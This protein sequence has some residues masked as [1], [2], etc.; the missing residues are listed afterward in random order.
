MVA[1]EIPADAVGGTITAWFDNEVLCQDATNFA[2][3]AGC[4][5]SPCPGGAG[6]IGGR[7]FI[8][9][10]QDGIHQAG[11]TNG[12]ADVLVRLYECNASGASVF[13]SNTTT[14]INGDYFFTGLTD[15]QKYRLEFEL[16]PTLLAAGLRM[17]NNGADSRTSVQFYTAPTCDVEFGVFP[18]ADFCDEN[19]L[20][21]VPCYSRGNPLVAGSAA[22]DPALVGFQ[23]N[24]TGNGAKT[25]YAIQSQVGSLW[26]EAYDK[27]RKRMYTSS[28]LRR[29]AGLGPHGLYGLYVTDMTLSPAASTS[30]FLDL[31]TVGVNLGTVSDNPGRGLVGDKTT[32][33][34]DPEAF[35]KLGKVGIG[36]IDISDD[37]STLYF[38]NLFS[39]KLQSLNIDNDGNPATPYVHTAADV[40]EY[41][42][43]AGISCTG[44]NF[45]PFALKFY[46]GKVY[47]GAVCDAQISQN[48]SDLRAYV[49]EFTPGAN[50][51][52][53]LFDFPLT[54]PKG[55]PFSS[56][57]DRPGWYPWT[58]TWSDITALNGG[59]NN[60]AYPTP[61][62]CDIEFDIDGS[63]VLGF[64]DRTAY[65][66]GF[67]DYAP[68]GPGTLYR[69]FAGGDVL[70]VFTKNGSY[71]LE[72][73]GQAG[74]TAGF[75]ANNNQGPGFGEFY[76]DIWQNGGHSEIMLGGLA[77]R[78]GSG[79]V[80]AVMMDP[81]LLNPPIWSNGVRTLSNLT[82]GYV[83]GF[84]VFQYSTDP[85][86]GTFGKAAGLGDIE[87]ICAIP[88]NIQIGNRVWKDD[89][90]N[91]IQEPCE[92]PIANVKVELYDADGDLVG[93]T[94]TNANGE[95]YF[96]QTNVDTI[97]PYGTGGFTGMSATTKYFVVVGKNMTQFNT[98]S[99]ELKIGSTYYKLSLPPNVGQAPDFDINDS[100][101]N[102]LAGLTGSLASL[103]GYPGVMITSPG[104]G[105]VNH[106][107]DFA[108]FQMVDCGD[109]PD[110][111]QAGAY[112]TNNTNG[113]G[114]G[115]GACHVITSALKMGAL[116]DA[117]PQGIPST[118]ADGDDTGASDDEDGVS[119]PAFLPGQ[120][121]NITVSVM[122]T[123]GS[124]AK[125]T[126]FFDW[127]TDGDFAD[128]GEM[129]SVNV[130]D[131]TNGN[132]I[133]SVSVPANAVVNQLLGMR[134]RLST[135]AAASMIPVGLAPNGEVE[136]YL[137]KVVSFDWGDLPDT[138]PGTGMG[139]YQVTAADNGPNH[140]VV[141]NLKIGAS[142][143]NEA[144]GQPNGTATGDGADENGIAAFPQFSLGQFAVVDVTVMN[145]TG[146]AAILYGFFD[147]NKD[148][149][150]DDA[151]EQTSVAVPNG[152]NGVLQLNPYVP[153]GAVV[154]MPLGAR[155]RLSTDI[156]AAA[157]PVGP[158]PDGEV[159]DYLITVIALDYGDLP[160]GDNPGSY[161]TNSTDGG[162]GAG[163]CHVIVDGLK[164]GDSV[165]G[166]PDGQ[167]N[168]TAAGD[169]TNGIDD[170]NGIAAFPMFIA[171]QNATVGVNVM[172]T[173]GSTAILYGFIDWN[174]DG[175]FL[176][177]N[178][179]VTTPVVNNTMGVVNLNFSVPANAVLNMDLGARFR[180]S[181]AGNLT[182]TGPSCA[183]NGEVE[184]YL[185]RVM[186]FDYGDLPDTGPGT[187][188]G[189][190]QTLVSDNGPSHKIVAGLKMGASVDD[191][192]NGQ[193][194]PTA[195]GDGADEN[196]VAAFPQFAAGQPAVIQVNVMNMTGDQA[197]LYGFFDWNKDG[198]F[199]DPNEITSFTVPDGTNGNV[200]L[201]VNVPGD[202][203]VNMPL[204]ARLRLSTDPVAPS[205]PEGP[206]PD[207]EVEDY[208]VTVVAIDYG[209]LAD[210]NAPGSY[211]TDATNGGGEGVGPS[212]VINPNLKLGASVDGE[213]AGQP[214][215]D[216]NGDD[217]NKTP[218]D[219]DGVTI[220]MFV[221][222]TPADV[223]I[224]FMNMTGGNAKLTLFI[225][226]NGNGNFTDPGEMYSTTV[227]N[228]AANH[229]FNV[230]PPPGSVLNTDIGVRVRL[231]TDVAASMSP[232]GPAPDGEVEDYEAQ[233]MAFDFGDLA[234]NDALG[235][236][237]TNT[238]DGGGEGVGPSHKI[239]AGLKMG[240][241]IDSETDG[242][243]NA[244]ATGD[245]A[246]ED[247]IVSFPLFAAG[248]PA[249][250]DVYVMNMTGDQAVLYGF[251]DWN[252]DG[253]FDDAN[254][255]TKL[256]VPDG[257]NNFVPLNVNVPADVVVNMPLGA[258]FRLSTDPV[259]PSTAEGPAP[260]GEVEDYQI[261]VVAIDYGDL[262][263]ND[264]PGSYPTNTTDGG[265]G[266]G[267]GHVV[268]PGI[269]IGNRVDGEPNG[270]PSATAN[271]DD[272]NGTPDDEDGVVLP[273]LIEGALVNVPVSVM[274]MRDLDA[275]LTIFIDW[276][277]NGSFEPGEMYFTTVSSGTNGIVNVPVQVP[278]GPQLNTDLGIRVRLST[279][280]QASMSPTGL[281]PDGEVE[282]YFGQV[283][284]FDWGDLP[285][286]NNGIGYATNS[287][288]NGEGFGPSHKIVDG[289]KLGASVDGELDGQASANADG[290]DTNA[291]DENGIAAFPTFLAGEATTI[292]VN[293]MNMTGDQ[294]V[295]FGFIDWNKDGDFEDP[296]EKVSVNVPDGT[297]GVMPLNVT[298]PENAVRN[299]PLGAR[300]RLSTDDVAAGTPEGPAPDGEV[301]DY[302]VEVVAYD[303]G[304]LPDD[305]PGTGPG[306]YETTP[307]D[308]GP[309]HKVVDGLKLGDNVDF[310][311]A[312]QP[313]ANADGDD[314]A[315][316]DDENGVQLPMFEVNVPADISV[317]YMNMTGGDAKLTI[318]IDWNGDGDFNDPGEMYATTVG[319]NTNNTTISV[320][321]P[322]GAV[323]NQNIGIRTRLSTDA[324]ASMSPTGPAP[325][326]EV[327]DQ[328]AQVMAFDYGDL[329]D[330]DAGGAYPTN[331]TD[332]GEGV[333][334]S[335]KIVDGLKLGA[336][337]DPETDGQP[338]GTANGDDSNGVDDENGVTFPTLFAGQPADLTVTVMNMTGAPA[339][340]FTYIDWNKDGD[341]DDPGEVTQ[342]SIL[343]GTNGPVQVT[344]NV[345]STAVINMPLGARFRLTNDPAFNGEP[346][347]PAGPGEVEDYYVQVVGVDYGDLADND[348]PGSYP[349]NTTDGGEGVGPS[350]IIVDGLKIGPSVDAEG[351][352]QSSTG[353]NGDD[354]ADS[355]DENGIAAFPQFTAGENA[356]VTVNV[357]NMTEGPAKLTG[358]IDWNGDG[359][360]DDAGEMTSVAV[361][362]GTNG[363]VDLTFAVPVN[364][365]L[366]EDLG[367]RFRLST[368]AQASMSP[369]GPAPDGEVEDYNVQ[370]TCPAIVSVSA[371]T[372]EVCPDY[373]F[374]VTVTHTPSLGNLGIY[375]S[376][377]GALTAAELYDFAN[378]GANGILPLE[379]FVVT[380]D[381]P[382]EIYNQTIPAFGNFTIYAILADG[383]PFISDPNCLPM[384]S[385]PITV[386]DDNPPAI[387]CPTDATVELDGTITGGLLNGQPDLAIVSSG[388]CGVTLDYTQ[389]VGTDDCPN[390][391]TQLVAGFGAAPN[392]YE[393]NG[394]YTSVWQVT[395]NAGH[396]A[397]CSF[398]V[399]IED[400]IPPVITC[401][402]DLTINT[403][404]GECDAAVTYAH[405]LGGDNCPGF[406][407]NLVQGPQSGDEF[408]LGETTVEYQITDDMG[409]TTTC[410]FTV[411]V[412][413]KEKP[414]ISCPD[415][416]TVYTSSDGLGD[417]AGLVPNF[418]PG[419]SSSD[420]CTSPLSNFVQ[421]PA[422]GTSVNGAH[423]QQFDVVITVTDAAGN[424]NSCE[425][426][427][428]L[429]DDEAPT[430]TPPSTPV[431]VACAQDVPAIPVLTPA[432]NCGI[433][434]DNLDIDFSETIT[435]GTCHDQFTLTRTWIVTDKAGNT[436]SQVQVI[437][438]ND[439]AA[440]VWNQP[441]PASPLTYQCA[442]DVPA[443][444]LQ[445]ANDNCGKPIYVDFNEILTPGT[446]H[447][448]FTIT[449]TWTAMDDC[450]NATTRVQVINVNDTTNPFWITPAP[451]A[452]VAVNCAD[453]V[454]LPSIQL[455]LD[456]CRKPVDLEYT[457]VLI[458][459]DCHDQFS[460]FRTWT[461]ADDCGNV[462]IRTQ[463]VVVEDAIKPVW[464]QLAPEPVVNVECAEDVPPAPVQT[465]W[466]N[467]GVPIDVELVELELPGT[468]PNQ[469][470]ITRTWTAEDACG[471]SVSRQQVINV[472]D[473]QAPEWLQPEPESPVNL[474]CQ[475]DIPPVPV[476]TVTDNCD[477]PVF[478]EFSEVLTPGGCLNSFSLTRTWF[479]QDDCGNST[480]RQ[481]V[482]NVN[483]DSA[484]GFVGLPA[485]A[486]VAVECSEDVP[487][488][489]AV[490]A[491]DNC[492]APV[493]VEFTEVEIPGT[494]PNQYQ[495]VRT[496]TAE[497]AC[498][499]TDIFVQTITISD[500]KA[501]SWNEAAPQP[502]VR[503][504]CSEDVP[505]IPAQTASDN[506]NAP[507][508]LEFNESI[509]PGT[510]A[511]Q[512]SLTRTWTAEDD[513]GNITTR[514]QVI[515]VNDGEKPVL[516]GLPAEALVQVECADAVPDV[517]VV[518]ATDN[519]AEPIAPDFTEVEEP[520]ACPNQYTIIRT[521]TAEDDCGNSTYFVQ[522]II[523][524]DTEAPVLGV[525]PLDLNLD[526][527]E[528][529]PAAPAQWATDNCGV[530]FID[531]SESADPG[532][533]SCP[534]S[535]VITRMWIASDLCGNTTSWWQT[536]TVQDNEPP[537]LAVT[538]IDFTVECSDEVPL[539]PS[540]SA[541]DNCGV[542][543]V[544]FAEFVQPGGCENQYVIA[545]RWIATDLCGNADEH[546]QF[547]TVHD[548]EAP[549]LPTK[550]IDLQV[551]CS[552]DVP[553]AP[554][555]VAT[556][557]CGIVFVD[558]AEEIQPGGCENQYVVVRRWTATDLCGNTAEHWQHITVNDVQAPVLVGLPA[559]VVV[560]VECSEDVPSVPAVFALDNCDS[561][562]DLE[563]TEIE[564]PG[565]CPN[566]YSIVRTWSVEDACGNSKV[567]TQT[568]N[569]SDTE[570]PVLAG[571]P[572]DAVVHVEC[573]EDM[574]SVPA[575]TATDNCDVPIVVDFSEVEIPGTCAN[576]Y[577]ITRTWTAQD[578]C[579]NATSFVQTIN[580]SDTEAPALAGLP[581][582]AVVNVECS[583]DVPAVPAVTATDNC[584]VPIVVDFSEVE[585]PGTCPNQYS[586]T[587]TWTAQDDCGNA[588][589]FV[590]TI[591]VS[592]T[593]APVLSG[594]PPAVVDVACSEDVPAMAIVTAIDNC[595]APVDIEF[596]EKEIPG[597][598]P[599]QYSI[600][601]TWTAEDDCGNATSFVQTINV[602]DT[603]APVMAGLPT[604]AVVNLECSEDVPAV[605]VVTVTDNCNQLIILDFNEVETPGTCANQYS[606][607]RTW[608]AQDDCGN[609]TSFVQTI[610]VSDTEAPVLS[611]L[612]TEAV[613]NVECSE[614]VPAVP[615]VSATDNCQAPIVVDFNEVETPGT[616]ANQYSITRTWTAQDDCGN[617]T[618]FVQ[619]IN[620]SD[621]EA[622]ALAG[623]PTDAVVNVECSED[624]PAVPS[625]SATDNC[626]API[627]VD[628]SEVEIPGTCPN[629]YTITRTWSAQDDCG[630]ATSFVQTINVSDTEAPVLSGL[631]TEA[632]V[633]V[634]CSEDVPAVP[635]VSATDNCQAPIAVDFSEVEIPG[636][637]P[638]QY[639]IT[640]TW[641]AQDDC[642]NATSFVQTINV[643][644]TEAPALAGL[645]TDAVVNVECS[646]D[647]PAVP[648]VSATDN[649]QAPIVVDFSEVE[650][651]GTCP[652]QYTI[653][654]TWSVQDDCGNAT[655]FVQTINVS[656]T[657]APVLSGLPTDAVVNVE[658]SEDVPAVPVVSATDNCQA[659]IVV[660]FSEVEAPGSCAN[661]Y[662]I[663][664]TWS[665]QDDCG[666]AASF[667]QTINVNDDIAP[668]ISCPAN[669]F[670]QCT[671]DEIPVYDNLA[672]FNTAGGAASDNCGLD[673]GTFGLLS[674]TQNGNVYTRTY[675]IA[676]ACG[677]SAT[678]TQTITVLDTEAPVFVNC[679]ANITVGNDVDKC[680]ANVVFST[681]IAEDNCE[682][683]S[684]TQ[685]GGLP[686]GSL[687]PVGQ[688]LITF[689]AADPTGNTAVC[690][691]TIEVTDMQTPT[692]V[693][694]DLTVDLDNA[695]LAAISAVQIG[696][697]STDNCPG[698]L[699]LH[700]AQQ[701][702]IVQ[703]SVQTV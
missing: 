592:D 83:N 187:G 55:S 154:N 647:V 565:T 695:G 637:C 136:D 262:P 78:P 461:A 27:D 460:I 92:D 610:N 683:E 454:P 577:S 481:Q 213:P 228:L 594:L 176:D 450:G 349:T 296:N 687:F 442:E 629:Q 98:A 690:Q 8:D 67:D 263:D 619:T 77:L 463:L 219:E 643:S 597:T 17:G 626:Q 428:T 80:M 346:T 325:D 590:Q 322:A 130:P 438:V 488:V 242:Q 531:F 364:S 336:S 84:V 399:V 245:G 355:D 507:V 200:P 132:V 568:I 696:G 60:I 29:H 183:P 448:Q 439:T 323:L 697:N 657:E 90:Q 498:G 237:P 110:D 233:V 21:I 14:D 287:N 381:N 297:N 445:T 205:S 108:F 307:G 670:A 299:M 392:Y 119:L 508:D 676:D 496:W 303:Y 486:T 654:R 23:Y 331:D 16:T 382:T 340:L 675:V 65:Q 396:T 688:T 174:K 642:G 631:P 639:T 91:G 175:D 204:G 651:P 36:D 5:P 271:G 58:D 171:G 109:L 280:A 679:P 359:D 640:R 360:F 253:D 102:Y 429:V 342:T 281:A 412:E 609:A 143:D 265:E 107:Y 555:Q 440:P 574:P 374:D 586:I 338:S 495:V 202:V 144:D 645:P 680:G 453:D 348:A 581:T 389:P 255:S 423:G 430:L 385:T 635:V 449:R 404:P 546:W 62:F 198:D 178:E 475:E 289:L 273:M 494:C 584:D 155:F 569:V 394:T 152:Y 694:T 193:P 211:P 447:D 335:H 648:S 309:S 28:F 393:Y 458:P 403:D 69:G 318:F 632:V 650:I 514:V 662:V 114:E 153:M 547:I 535:T 329:A 126:G 298:V 145:M 515:Q 135:D 660:D 149:D 621:T 617:A 326:G 186:A 277:G 536:I 699:I 467:C 89:N 122:N 377:N 502:L 314:L 223:S 693:C 39:G 421:S 339:E 375:Y 4:A 138:G 416:V 671:V 576:Q 279:D 295:L 539:A 477:V 479:A 283:M 333:G 40:N 357:M 11:E 655:S 137:A 304:D 25:V 315:G 622:P 685:T 71:V 167:P 575:V 537:V 478:V 352:G 156:A 414:E 384:A 49:L 367:A 229:V 316:A 124:T 104:F 678:C 517:P 26:G 100:D 533:V 252:K 87:L 332:G 634:E 499:N 466:D 545:R 523:V 123:T 589:S 99:N 95:Y 595:D 270:Q 64:G 358:F 43:T 127:N 341:L 88:T 493:D 305:A 681:P 669:A 320:T 30:L 356:T 150:F 112:P 605:P 692:A 413:D 170:D 317:T 520:G 288:N 7:A 146:Q 427:I 457:E 573:S 212:H 285:D 221:L 42:I 10:N 476:Q 166:D 598:C 661:Q 366:N 567:F 663:T 220:P 275:K 290:D 31:S 625:V 292:N 82:G 118:N 395:D 235:S 668:S 564:I 624:V 674:Q 492:D 378:H 203:V 373:E 591:N 446:C 362:D 272:A 386:V 164:I 225:D 344:V 673:A 79:Q 456:N 630:N 534:N 18:P 618:S 549:V 542:V 480:S 113:A 24:A 258:R 471:N 548:D 206:A 184:D 286:L 308:N 379:D 93:V 131:G 282:D 330:D 684:V 38:V 701:T 81:M 672:E 552:E 383:N 12:Q 407:F 474:A 702:L 139:N 410:S 543:N 227:A 321:P 218:D 562:V 528:D 236:Y 163:P 664:R 369:T 231:S 248:Q 580:V 140:Q 659:P 652:N 48:K 505:P 234:D 638:N 540:Q 251:F 656:D 300:F 129:A 2:P 644:D 444:P 484:P 432:D 103:N 641:S 334:A 269:K 557:N 512:F 337:V 558:F 268:V 371:S 682:V 554:V 604:E 470:Q 159:E 37:G 54:Y 294:A 433:G 611:G 301:E 291:D 361:P 196:G 585:I 524:N 73:N 376:T 232:T 551:N 469:L 13:V 312:G 435:P 464:N 700:P 560:D 94:T 328:L 620:V 3:P 191:E 401:P 181:T 195:T 151:N 172:N 276:N 572:T 35:T 148:G 284:A 256:T 613:V 587:R 240:G 380:G 559:D 411:T 677:N 207:G 424:A 388:P 74:T 506:C 455:A 487:A 215:I 208:L 402:D 431:N 636:T 68:T 689:V 510:C 160:D 583:E 417:C 365:E 247:G 147:W 313:A 266:P 578:D 189:N 600:T 101:G 177:A 485:E 436:T 667:V 85:G 46:K 6:T 133:L 391:L 501:P 443:V 649:C 418:I 459:G 579:G 698:P 327:E 387:T 541:S 599:N 44:G 238:L 319:N 56:V 345:P 19:P 354:L 490:T 400:P 530:V 97:A 614:D 343:N 658:C 217:N 222:N 246:D 214:S 691:F 398:T 52:T 561:P 76:N 513:C 311:P 497:D 623:L 409:N 306:N 226:W 473:T 278:V 563:F 511:N 105:D 157:A 180:I 582:E 267:A 45:R 66:L 86:T 422:A 363:N 504:S 556:D 686:S 169:D 419:T 665:A 566:Q 491:T 372:P 134:F 553:P 347:G 633:N 390:P 525:T 185:I 168:A 503:V 522:T 141:D 405:P 607:T 192:T 500:T 518:T 216:A 1:F 527:I 33:N 426:E 615:A 182:A 194:N 666:N 111:D 41:D 115:V 482:I 224:S 165:D 653:T 75:G 259:A 121:A 452:E 310:E 350:H 293:V 703:T 521:W 72:N 616:C 516:H 34:V 197:V 627:V 538:P 158:A 468:C 519:C 179:T 199:D 120:L 162:E 612:P 646:E 96:D 57:N 602:S 368:D 603:E 397:S 142:V 483:D 53:V 190:Y 462:V 32:P 63:M 59:N 201:N 254:E 274:N 70:R 161:P 230:T 117:E 509:A 244:N 260:D 415:D 628:F 425:L 588:T 257:T 451:Q 441:A 489:P 173:I 324:Q 51:T 593:E 128:A 601:R 250:V 437:N 210:N 106:T 529:V 22:G 353:A 243:P 526:C 406:T 370:V 408:P 20:V 209:D 596:S 15:G 570:A 241:T 606:I 188:T 571:L 608:T 9:Y 420:N 50:T 249:V 532:P 261:V 264:Q 239:I 125:L 544:D 61:M 47:I 465:A 434:P 116:V 550:P 351:N 472:N 302:L